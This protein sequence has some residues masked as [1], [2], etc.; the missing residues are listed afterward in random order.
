MQH[1]FI[2]PFLFQLVNGSSSLLYVFRHNHFKFGI[3]CS[4]T[5]HVHAAAFVRL[6]AWKHFPVLSYPASRETSC[7]IRLASVISPFVFRLA[8]VSFRYC[9]PMSWAI[10]ISNLAFPVL[11][12]STC[13][14]V[15]ITSSLQEFSSLTVTCEQRSHRKNCTV[16]DNQTAILLLSLLNFLCV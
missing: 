6:R 3:S 13:R 14:G 12:L 16:N 7:N 1:S 2:S 5:L 15:R 11:R 8:N 9:I 10:N 4:S